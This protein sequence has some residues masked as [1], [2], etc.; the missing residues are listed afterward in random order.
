MSASVWARFWTLCAFGVTVTL[1][2]R[3]A[4][5]SL[6]GRVTDENEAPVGEARITLR[7]A[8]P[9][10]AE[11][12]RTQADP[13]G[14]FS[15]DIPAAGDYLINVERE[16]YYELK[17]RP[18][19]IEG[20]TE[21]TLAIHTVR[22]VFQSVNVN[23]QP[24][25]VDV[26]QTHNQERLTG[27]EVNDILYPNSHSFRNA[28]KLMPGVVEDVSGG[29]HFNGSSENQVQYLL[30]GFDITDPISGQFHT[31]LAVEGVR[32][33]DYLSERYSPEFGKG[34]AGVLAIRTENG[35][36]NFHYTATDFIP[37]LNFQQ[38][39]RLGNWYPRVGASGPI[40]RG[41]AW[42]SDNLESEYNTALVTGLPSGQ[43]TRSGWAGSNLLHTQFNLTPRNILYTEFLVNLDYENRVGL[44]PLDPVST[45]QTVHIHQYM[46]GVRDLISLG[47]GALVEMGYAHNAFS[48]SQTPQ[49]QNIYVFSPAGRSGN[50]FVTGSQTASR[51]QWLVHAYAPHFHWR[52]LHQVE[53]GVD[54]DLVR[55]DGNFA[56]TGYELL[57]LSGQVLSQTSFTG[58]G[59]FTIRDTRMAAWLLDTWRIA[60]RLQIDAG[61]RGDR[62]QLVRQ[63]GWA[64]RIAFSWSPFAGG[65]TRVA[66]GY[67][68]TYDAV[69]LDPFGR[70]QDQS[71]LTTEYTAAGVASGPPVP[72]VFQ[73]SNEALK[74]PRAANW[75]VGVDHEISAHLSASV[76]YLRRRGTDGFDFL[77]VLAPDA[78]PSL[79]PLP[80]GTAAGFYQ[81]ANLRRD[82]FD[83]VQFIVRQTFSG[84]YEWMASYTRSRAQSNAVLDMNTTEPLQ[85]LPVLV[86][87]PWDSPNRVLGRAY[88]PLPW[89]YWSVAVLGDARTGFP[90]SVQDQTGVVSGTVNSHRYPFNFDLNLAIERMVTFHGYRFALRG[91]VDNLSDSRNPTAVNNVIG[92]PQ[93]LQFLGDEGRH[94]VVRIRF[95]GRAG[96]K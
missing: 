75:S 95:F 90:F 84:Q 82:D 15:I 20:P 76:K 22:E 21:I 18:L 72:T 12:L 8:G 39:V 88:L 68:V 23:E 37:G 7:P 63:I 45:T 85:I 83:S 27:T 80:N 64:P 29:M 56:R 54:A 66:G 38:G 49:G 46:G 42:F 92:A 33:V 93:Y 10:P 74:L 59:L 52:G 32:S 67:A 58:S 47:S 40:D 77:N 25:P 43:N 62:D 79:L 96:T 53:A 19:H 44:S 6:R 3:P 41:H 24:S 70:L 5:V 91:G 55:Y 81:L 36:D 13:A 28:M 35:S 31:I 94:F 60:T 78:P 16:G 30:N 87:M 57:G 61:V 34:T 9:S 1:A 14:A 48:S 2:V 4:D 17:G 50:Y 11:P 73:R 89:K 65:H 86:P 51:D 71:A 26:S 69:P